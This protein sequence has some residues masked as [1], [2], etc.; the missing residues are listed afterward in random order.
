MQKH[1][2]KLGDSEEV[3]EEKAVK[4]GESFTG[5]MQMAADIAGTLK[6]SFGGMSEGLDMRSMLSRE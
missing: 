4:F 5:K 6:E 2:M 1:F 3:A